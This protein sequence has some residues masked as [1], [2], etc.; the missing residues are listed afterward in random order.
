MYTGKSVYATFRMKKSAMN[1]I[2]DWFGNE[3]EF[4]DET[5]EEVSAR[6]RVNYEAMRRLA[7][8]LSRNIWLLSPAD[9]RE[10]VKEDLA[11]ALLRY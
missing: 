8:Q 4:F 6:V 9:L 5:E 1:E 3:L 2:I 10:Q 7:V 11:N